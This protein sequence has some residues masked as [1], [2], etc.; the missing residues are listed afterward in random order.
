MSL[1]IFNKRRIQNTGIKVIT[2]IDFTR[3]KQNTYTSL[4]STPDFRFLLLCDTGI[5]T[6]QSA[7]RKHFTC[8][9]NSIHIHILGRRWVDFFLPILLRSESESPWG[10][11]VWAAHSPR[12]FYWWDSLLV[13]SNT[14]NQSSEQNVLSSDHSVRFGS[15]TRAKSI[16]SLHRYPLPYFPMEY[17]T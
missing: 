13:G 5:G 15:F 10:G 3:K 7:N 4:Q 9:N 11:A 2:I 8:K 1:V 17:F 12:C 6:S 14:A 16:L